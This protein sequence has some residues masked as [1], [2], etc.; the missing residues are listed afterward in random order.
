[1]LG[2][3]RLTKLLY[4]AYVLALNLPSVRAL[5]C[6]DAERL[7]REAEL[8]LRERQPVLRRQILS[9]GIPI[10]LPDGQSLLRGESVAV[11]PDGRGTDVASRGWVDL[12]PSNLA[13][14]IHRASA[15][16]E[17]Q[18]PDPGTGS[19]A[20]WTAIAPDAAIEPAKLATWI[21]MVE[22][23]GFRVQR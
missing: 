21:F 1:M 9:V 15:I 4:E 12:R 16:S 18:A 5:A 3:P 19:G 6:A 11:P 17:Q 7:A 14:W 8:T 13:Q 20:P 10:L 22:D 23:G 2:P